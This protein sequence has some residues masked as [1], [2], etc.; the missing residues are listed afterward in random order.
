MLPAVPAVASSVRG[1]GLVTYSQAGI[2]AA[3]DCKSAYSGE[4]DRSF[5]SIVTA[6]HE[7]V[8]RG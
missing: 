2:V 8:L 6:A 3:C 7:M 1:T 4:R 5:R